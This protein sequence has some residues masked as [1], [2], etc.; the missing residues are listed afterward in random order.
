MFISVTTW[1]GKSAKE[2]ML[3]KCQRSSL[4]SASNVQCSKQQDLLL[5]ANT[6]AHVF[7]TSHFFLCGAF[8][9]LANGH[10]LLHFFDDDIFK[11]NSTIY[12]QRTPRPGHWLQYT[13][14]KHLVIIHMQQ[15]VT[16]LI[17]QVFFLWQP[18][19][20]YQLERLEIIGAKK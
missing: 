9:A 8:F 4:Y 3:R 17:M 6:S 14:C 12:K 10:K 7:E 15:S 13:K 1:N 19:D 16:Q 5:V 2:V 11:L 18:V 20:S